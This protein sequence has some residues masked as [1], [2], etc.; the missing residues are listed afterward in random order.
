MDSDS[1]RLAKA[2]HVIAAER[3]LRAKW[4]TNSS[5]RGWRTPSCAA[6]SSRCVARY[7]SEPW[8]TP[9]AE[10]IMAVEV[11]ATL[12]AALFIEVWPVPVFSLKPAQPSRGASARGKS[13]RPA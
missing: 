11:H 1:L 10:P 4:N 13:G 12:P 7:Q 6:P 2:Q 9:M 5:W 3:A 8:R